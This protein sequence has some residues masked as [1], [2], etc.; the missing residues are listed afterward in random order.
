MVSV[1]ERVSWLVYLELK[2][3]APDGSTET[4]TDQE[5]TSE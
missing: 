5:Q 4:N 2:Q 1:V 3:D